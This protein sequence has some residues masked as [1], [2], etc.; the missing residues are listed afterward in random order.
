MSAMG[1]E[2]TVT[3]GWKADVELLGSYNAPVDL[4]RFSDPVQLRG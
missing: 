3:Y 4:F 2:L 1:R